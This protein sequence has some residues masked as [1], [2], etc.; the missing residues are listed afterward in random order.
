MKET[1]PLLKKLLIA[2]VVIYVVGMTIMLSDMYAK[3]GTIEH[4]LMHASAKH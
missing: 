1:S 3:I 2:A 4:V